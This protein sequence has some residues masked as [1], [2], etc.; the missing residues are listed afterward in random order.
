MQPGLPLPLLLK[1]FRQ[2]EDRWQ[3]DPEIKKMVEYREFNLLADPRPFGA[4]DIVFCRNVLIYFDQ[5]LKAE[6]LD[7]IRSVI[8]EDGILYLGGAETV[9]GVTDRFEPMPNERGLYRVVQKAKAP[10]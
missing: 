9:L 10:V 3:I 7:R 1:Y 2:V 5:P 8:A 6:V 4:F